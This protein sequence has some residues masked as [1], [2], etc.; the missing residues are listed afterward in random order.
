MD[1]KE[2]KKFGVVIDKNKEQSRAEQPE[3]EQNTSQN[4]N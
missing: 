3:G 4:Q 1:D 2:K